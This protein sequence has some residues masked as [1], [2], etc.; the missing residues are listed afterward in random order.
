MFDKVTR[1]KL[2]F[3]STKGMLTVEDLWDLSL[4]TLNDMAKVLNKKLKTD[5]ESDFLDET[6]KE[7]SDDRLRFDTV[8]H[9]LEVKKKEKKDRE[10]QLDKKTKRERLLGLLAEKQ[11]AQLRELSVDQIKEELTK[12]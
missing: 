12:L 8:L 3:S 10:E 11:D 5:Q 9:I 2:R 4:T 1:N 7:N 6:P